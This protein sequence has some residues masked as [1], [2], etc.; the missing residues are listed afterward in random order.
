[1]GR[2][3]NDGDRPPGGAEGT[4]D[5]LGLDVEYGQVGV[6]LSEFGGCNGMG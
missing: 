6:R 5:L 1:M 4:G 3:G 2:K